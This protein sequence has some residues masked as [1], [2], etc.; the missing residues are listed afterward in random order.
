[1]PTLRALMFE[2]QHPSHCQ[3][4]G[5]L[6]PTSTSPCSLLQSFIFCHLLESD[7]ISPI[8]PFSGFFS[9]HSHLILSVDLASGQGLCLNYWAILP[10]ASG[11]YLMITLVPLIWRVNSTYFVCNVIVPGFGQ[12]EMF[13]VLFLK[14]LTT[15]TQVPSGFG[16]TLYLFSSKSLAIS[17]C[18]FSLNYK[19]GVSAWLSP[20]FLKL[21]CLPHSASKQPLNSITMHALQLF[22]K[23][24][25]ALADCSLCQLVL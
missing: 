19:L 25:H 8:C 3:W 15:T 5:S 4:G 17:L 14:W 23:H 6:V 20:Q 12:T 2:H 10:F 16:I 7:T 24:P 11:Q 1:M 9:G 13:M 18:S 21:D 22:S